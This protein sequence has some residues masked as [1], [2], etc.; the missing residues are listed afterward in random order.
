MKPLGGVARPRGGVFGRGGSQ[1][2]LA[3]VAHASRLCGRVWEEER[4]GRDLRLQRNRPADDGRPR[5]VRPPAVAVLA[6]Q[7]AAGRRQAPPLAAAAA[8]SGRAVAA[9]V[10]VHPR[11]EAALARHGSAHFD[12]GV[13]LGGAAGSRRSG[14][15][16]DG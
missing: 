5:C 8:S 15:L 9:A 4:F 10:G 12:E 1:S 6:R 13:A 16:G 3:S 11:Q 2:G 14:I 7:A